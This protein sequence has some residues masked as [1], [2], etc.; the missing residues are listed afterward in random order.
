MTG[1]NTIA[2]FQLSAQQARVWSQQAG[3]S[4]PFRAECEVL[5]EG[6]LDPAALERAFVDLV[7]RHEILRTVFQR[8]AG[9]KVPFQV[10]QETCE[11]AWETVDLTGLDEAA[12]RARIARPPAAFDLEHGPLLQVLLATLG[13]GKHTLLVSLPALC[14]DLRSMQNLIAEVAGS[15]A[16]DARDADETMQY[17]DVSAWLAMAA[18]SGGACGASSVSPEPLGCNVAITLL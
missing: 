3:D 5:I 15:Y 16:A 17:A 4:T 1:T 6:S 9:M 18:V 14:A 11:F 2:G 13:P 12:Q 8:Q 10:I 7:G